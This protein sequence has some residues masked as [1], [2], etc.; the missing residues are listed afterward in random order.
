M[1]LCRAEG[2]RNVRSLLGL[3]YPVRALLHSL[4]TKRDP[5]GCMTALLGQLL[6]QL[7][8]CF[9]SAGTVSLLD[10]EADTFLVRDVLAVARLILVHLCQCG[11]L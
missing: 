4:V 8:D 11:W 3:M 1:T 2:W 6:A 9:A 10:A 7:L 5:D